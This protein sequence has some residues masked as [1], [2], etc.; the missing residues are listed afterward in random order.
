MLADPNTATDRA[1]P[2]ASPLPA[3][4]PL[5]SPI[6]SRRHLVGLDLMRAVAIGMVLASHGGSYVAL[7]FHVP[8]PFNIAVAG[9]F[10]VELFFVL[11]G[12]LIGGLLIE[13]ARPVRDRRSAWDAWRVFML[14]RWMRTLPAY[15]AWIGVIAATALAG[16]AAWP[17]HLLAHLTLTQNLAWPMLADWFAVSWSLAVEEWFYLIFA[18]LIVGGTWLLGRRRALWVGVVLLLTVSPSLRAMLPGN[19]DWDQVTSKVVLYRL[20]AIGYGVAVACLL[21]GRRLGLAAALAC[22]VAGAGVILAIWTGQF[23]GMM[24]H[25]LFLANVIF[26]LCSVG[27]ALCLPAA[28]RA[29]AAPRWLAA[30]AALVSRHAYTLYLVHLTLLGLV[31]AWSVASG[32]GPW[33]ATAAAV[34]LIVL[35]SWALSRWVE[36]PVMARR[37]VQAASHGGVPRA[38]PPRRTPPT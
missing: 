18:S 32:R 10:G 3:S 15:Y 4:P 7:W 37:P 27:F 33:A 20:D 14:R 29:M 5:A 21:H 16:L 11:S 35:A 25:R 6:S 24:P 26:P 34:A 28:S 8:L 17:S 23:S 13:A 30:P 19:V 12:F 31:N 22:L 2:P 1:A 9:F 36:R 38:L